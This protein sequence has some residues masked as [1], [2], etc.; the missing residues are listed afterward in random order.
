[1]EDSVIN[2]DATLEKMN[3]NHT[4]AGAASPTK[5]LSSI[6]DS[7][8]I[9]S[10]Q[11]SGMDLPNFSHGE[12][13]DPLAASTQPMGLL[14]GEESLGT[15]ERG[16]RGFGQPDDFRYPMPYE[17]QMDVESNMQGVEELLDADVG[18]YTG[19]W[20]GAGSDGDEDEQWG[21]RNGNIGS[22]P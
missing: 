12:P 22:S 3:A 18:G 19:P 17:S 4:G 11:G 9:E 20:M 14:G 5:S 7:N 1:M 2:W 16:G 13:F 6:A 21:G 10:P 8:S 15:T